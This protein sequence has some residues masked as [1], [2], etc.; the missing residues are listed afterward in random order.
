MK[1]FLLPLS[2]A[3]LM[4]FAAACGNDPTAT[5]SGIKAARPS[6]A[7]VKPAASTAETPYNYEPIGKRD[8]FRSPLEDSQ[9]AQTEN[10]PCNEPLCQWELDQ[11]NLV[12]IVTGDANPLGMVEDPQGRGYIIRRNSKIGRRG[13]KVTQIM[14]GSVTVTELWTA[15]DGKVQPNPKTLALKAD[16]ETQPELDLSTGTKFTGTQEQ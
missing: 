2:V 4:V 13:G 16:K 12:A 9:T 3:G 7:D 10:A 5:A 14:R 11:L 6:G 8:P 1:T 15:A